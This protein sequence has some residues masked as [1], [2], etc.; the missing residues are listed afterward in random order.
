MGSSP[1]T[2][3]AYLLPELNKHCIDKQHSLS[4][5]PKLGLFSNSSQKGTTLGF[6]CNSDAKG[7]DLSLRAWVKAGE[8]QFGKSFITLGWG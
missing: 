3:R 2:G 8:Y 5:I 7:T 1:A 6:K 4:V